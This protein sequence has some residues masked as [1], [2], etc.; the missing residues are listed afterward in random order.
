MLNYLSFSICVSQS[1]LNLVVHSVLSR[2]NGH[3]A[4]V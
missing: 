4:G 3:S 1:S 2:S